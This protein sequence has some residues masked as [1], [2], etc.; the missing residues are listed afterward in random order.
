MLLLLFLVSPLSCV[1]TLF[2]GM[3]EELGTQ[4]PSWKLV[5]KSASR[6]AFPA[7][8]CAINAADVPAAANVPRV[9]RELGLGTGGRRSTGARHCATRCNLAHVCPSDWTSLQPFRP[10]GASTER[11]TGDALRTRMSTPKTVTPPKPS[12]EKDQGF[13]RSHGYG[14]GHGG[15][16]GP[17]DAPAAP[18]AP[19]A[20]APPPDDE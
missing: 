9:A 15:P 12:K 20:P 1:R 3:A 19:S 18:A 11:G 13:N 5:K 14:E 10:I 8:C 4:S 2:S 7:T 17:G 6:A 16:S